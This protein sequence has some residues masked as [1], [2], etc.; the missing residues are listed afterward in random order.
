MVY[1]Q[2]PTVAFTLELP[3]CIKLETRCKE[4]GMTKSSYLREVVKTILDNEEKIIA[5]QN[6]P[7]KDE[8]IVEEED[9]NV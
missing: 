6:T 7:S 5:I 3:Y 1:E 4:L 2:T 9:K 8:V